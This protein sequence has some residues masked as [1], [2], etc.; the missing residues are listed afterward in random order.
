MEFVNPKDVAFRIVNLSDVTLRDA[1]YYFMFID[2]DGPG[3][4]NLQ[5]TM[6]PQ[7]LP[8]PAKIETGDFLR[9]KT[10]FMASSIVSTF[11]GVQSIVKPNDRIF[12]LA[13]VS[14]PNLLKDRQYWLYF[15]VGSGGW[16]CEVPWQNMWNLR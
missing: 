3:R 4:F 2:I 10:S 9:P 1:K 8:T 16:Y 5:G 13:T 15:A 7:L 14:C 11:P 6:L 12:G